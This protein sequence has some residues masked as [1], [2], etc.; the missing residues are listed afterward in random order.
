[1][2]GDDLQRLLW[3]GVRGARPPYLVVVAG[4]ADEAG[5]AREDEGEREAG[6][7]VRD[8]FDPRRSMQDLAGS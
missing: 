8:A 2:L 6:E 4:H 5:D 3:G 7:A 1:M